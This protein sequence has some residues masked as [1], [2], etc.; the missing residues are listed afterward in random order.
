MSDPD[1]ST[2]PATRPTRQRK[3]ITA[4]FDEFD[5]FRSAQEIHGL[6][7]DKGER[8][9]L[10]TVYRTLQAMADTGLIDCLLNESGESIYRRCSKTHHH[11][12]LCR[13]CGATQEVSGPMVESWTQAIAKDHGYTNLT[14]RIEIIGI[15]AQCG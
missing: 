2:Q 8:V 5:G 4:I 6:L 11:H 12:L 13:E 1:N 7:S 3:A 15:C 10:A 14:H 9:G